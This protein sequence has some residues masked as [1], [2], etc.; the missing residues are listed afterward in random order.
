MDA[1]VSCHLT[2]ATVSHA[3]N[4]PQPTLKRHKAI[5]RI[6]C[7]QQARLL[8]SFERFIGTQPTNTVWTDSDTLEARLIAKLLFGA[9][10][11]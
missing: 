3:C 1:L 7:F 2:K 6:A 10:L 5:H 11:P 4:K 9:P 8:E